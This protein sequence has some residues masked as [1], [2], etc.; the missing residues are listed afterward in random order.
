LIDGDDAR[1]FRVVMDAAGEISRM[2]G[3]Q[4]DPDVAKA[5][6]ELIPDLPSIGGF[7]AG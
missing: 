4:F 6:V 5:F 7:Q 1:R 3:T 2:A